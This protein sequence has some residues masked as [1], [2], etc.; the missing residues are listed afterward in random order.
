VNPIPTKKKKKN[1]I[2]FKKNKVFKVSKLRSPIQHPKTEAETY[3][4][5]EK[6]VK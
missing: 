4:I 1:Q 3:K 5:K 6:K 2:N